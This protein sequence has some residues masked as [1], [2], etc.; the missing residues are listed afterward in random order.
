MSYNEILKL[1]PVAKSTLSIWLKGVGLAKKQKQ[2]L[3]EK[4]KQAQL[5][6]QQAC[7]QKRLKITTEIKSA[8]QREVGKISSRELWLLGV[9]LY[10]AEGT[11]QRAKNVSARVTFSNSDPEMIKLFLKWLMECCGIPK[12]DII[13]AIYL[14]K[15]AKSRE[16][17]IKKYWVK[18]TLFPL[19]QFNNTVW[20]NN[21]IKNKW[22]NINGNYYGLLR[23]VVNKSTN[24][25][26][27]I[28]GWIEGVYKY[29]GIV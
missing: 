7:T 18:A 1:V 20:K 26:R 10:W 15:T 24:L 14:H 27:K 12:K 23:I 16:G 19:S 13:L 8:A 3:T 11:K 4:R 5:K 2:R 21:K 29:S 17:E 25:N 9:A 22:R 28:S 6:A